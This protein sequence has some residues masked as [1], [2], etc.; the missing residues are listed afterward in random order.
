MAEF[1]TPDQVRSVFREFWDKSYDEIYTSMSGMADIWEGAIPGGGGRA[2]GSNAIFGIRTYGDRIYVMQGGLQTLLKVFTPNGLEIYDLGTKL[3]LMV[4]N[5]RDIYGSFTVI[6]ETELV[7]G[8]LYVNLDMQ[9]SAPYGHD[10]STLWRSPSSKYSIARVSS[11]AWV[12]AVR[13]NTG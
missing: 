9:F 13:D 11:S 4:H 1:I 5:N 3:S 12:W 8:Y 2:T 7:I 6:N 10:L